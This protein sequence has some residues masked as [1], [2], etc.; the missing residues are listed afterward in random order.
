MS[1]ETIAFLMGLLDRVTLHGADP[2]LLMNAQL[3]TQAR[4]ELIAAG[5]SAT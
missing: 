3:V 4:A 5:V 2:D 1:Q